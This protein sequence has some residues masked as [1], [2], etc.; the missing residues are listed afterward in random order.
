MPSQVINASL[1]STTTPLVN[2]LRKRQE[3][4]RFAQ[5]LEICATFTLIILFFVFAI[6]PTVLTISTLYSEIESKKKLKE[7][8]KVKI[9]NVIIA[10]SNFADFQKRAYLIDTTLPQEAE[11]A[12]AALQLIG[13]LEKNNIPVKDLSFEL[14]SALDP[15]LATKE[16]NLGAFQVSLQAQ[17]DSTQLNT[18]LE[19]MKKIR[20]LSYYGS[21]SISARTD[22]EANRNTINIGIVPQFY[23]INTPP[24]TAGP[25][26]TPNAK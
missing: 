12:N 18:I 25:K 26:P 24:I 20:R 7:E 5:L 8:L 6:R 17:V 3:N 1:T 19:D 14:N 22:K 4:E 10:Q 11:Y 23:Y 2:F 16:K 15:G 21:V 9:N 13:I